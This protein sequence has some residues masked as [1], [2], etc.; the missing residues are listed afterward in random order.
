MLST[1]FSLNW[2]GA[3]EEHKQLLTQIVTDCENTQRGD[4]SQTVKDKAM[5][6]LKVVK[7]IFKSKLAQKVVEQ[8]QLRA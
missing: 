2:S 8:S 1:Y 7:E 3:G 5:M 6:R 4:M